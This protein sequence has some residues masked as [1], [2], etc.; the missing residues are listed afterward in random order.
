MH[1]EEFVI[2]VVQPLGP[3]IRPV[4]EDV[5][6]AAST[7][8]F[9]DLLQVAAE[10]FTLETSDHFTPAM[11]QILETVLDLGNES[12]H[13]FRRKVSTLNLFEDHAA[14]SMPEQ[15]RKVRRPFWFVTAS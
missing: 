15:S 6:N 11:Y 12:A 10:C 2:K 4:M 8:P 5:P 1:G 7:A 13:F 9:A 14:W 3:M